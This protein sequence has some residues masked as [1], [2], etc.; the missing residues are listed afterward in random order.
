MLVTPKAR[1]NGPAFV[2]GWWAGIAIVGGAVLLLASGAGAND[3]GEPAGW[4]SWLLLALGLLLLLLAVRQ[5]QTRPHP[6]ETAETPKWMAAVDSFT[7]AK[8]AGMAA[9]LSGLNPKNLL[10]VVAGAAAI[11]QT[12]ISSGEQAVALIIFILIASLG[13]MV[14]VGLYFALGERSEAMLDGLKEWMTRHNAAIM[15]VLLVILGVKL[16]GNAISGL[17]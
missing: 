15:A 11:G 2:A 4:V 12:G 1:S 5:W 17:T 9:L 3:E 8:S 13:V 16:I 6:G 7:P 10:L 14:P